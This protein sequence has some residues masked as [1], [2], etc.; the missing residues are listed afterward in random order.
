LANVL[1]DGPDF[2]VDL[3][4]TFM[5]EKH[6]EPLV[7]NSPAAGD[8]ATVDARYR[9][10]RANF[11]A[12]AHSMPLFLV[13]G[14]HEGEAGWLNDGTDRNIAVWTS[15]ARKRYFVSPVPD[16]Y[17]GGD[18]TEEPHVGKRA[19]WYAWH[20]G[21]ALFVVLDPFWNTLGKVNRDAWVLTLGETQHRWLEATLAAS[22]ATFKFVFIHNLVGGLDGQMRGGIEAAP[23]FEWGGRGL[24]GTFDFAA[25]R[26]G[27]SMPIHP[28]LVRHGVTAVFHGHD[29][30]YARQELDGVVYQ[31]VPQP[32]ATNFQSGAALASEY[33]YASGTILGSSGHLRVSVGPDGTVVEYVRAWLPSAETPTR[34]NGQVDHR[35]SVGAR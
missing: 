3:G 9:Y 11:A 31:A 23:Y 28:L 13:N 12:V 17:Y 29:H 1:A 35:W 30:L 21:D 33:H 26:P 19:S 27:W 15:R 6:S 10:E 16:G 2:H 24:A 5:C 20:W 34:R 25:K 22:R 18:P 32:S 14:N 8:E 4:D 7:G